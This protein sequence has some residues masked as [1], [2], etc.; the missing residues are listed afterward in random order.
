MITFPPVPQFT[1]NMGE[2]HIHEEHLGVSVDY[3]GTDESVK[4]QLTNDEMLRLHA[5]PGKSGAFIEFTPEKY[6]VAIFFSTTETDEL[7]AYALWEVRANFR[8]LAKEE[9]MAN[10]YAQSVIA[11][12]RG[13][14]AHSVGENPVLARTIFSKDGSLTP[15]ISDLFEGN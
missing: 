11:L 15:D 10:A 4:K 2:D 9:S 5:I 13:Y 7:G 1:E 3:W 6:R 12:I 8:E 14:V